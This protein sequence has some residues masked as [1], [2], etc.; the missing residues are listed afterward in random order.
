[1]A[2]KAEMSV[3]ILYVGDSGVQPCSLLM[4]L[5]PCSWRATVMWRRAGS[6][7]W[8]ESD[9]VACRQQCATGI[10]NWITYQHLEAEREDHAHAAAVSAEGLVVAGVLDHQVGCTGDCFRRHEV[11]AQ[12]EERD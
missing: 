8:K 9:F 2:G 3:A 6:E 12:I 4:T 7:A 1:M 5:L 11:A 10:Y